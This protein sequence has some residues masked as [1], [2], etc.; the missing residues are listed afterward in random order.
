M[1]TTM[2][3]KIIEIKSND[4]PIS[5]MDTTMKKKIIEIKSNDI[6]ISTM[7]PF[8]DDELWNKLMKMYDKSVH[9]CRIYDEN[10]ELVY[11]SDDFLKFVTIDSKHI[12]RGRYY[13]KKEKARQEEFE[14]VKNKTTT[15]ICKGCK[16]EKP[17]GEFFKS[18]FPAR[19]L[20]NCVA[21]REETSKKNKEKKIKKEKEQKISTLEHK[22]QGTKQVITTIKSIDELKRFDKV[23][24]R[25]GNKYKNID[26]LNVKEE[27]CGGEV[28]RVN[29]KTVT[30]QIYE[31]E[32]Q[33]DYDYN[34]N[35]NDYNYR[36]EYPFCKRYSWKN[37]KF[38]NKTQT[39]GGLYTTKFELKEIDINSIL[40]RYNIT[41]VNDYDF[42]FHSLF[43]NGIYEEQCYIKY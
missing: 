5:T 43:T 7:N 3:E 9:L 8:D 15:H 30:L 26:D 39:K 28:T 33:K 29:K 36:N 22:V 18:K 35:D 41:K 21:C 11:A 34:D 12:I 31:L 2:K 4:I 42:H 23:I 20:I 32:E 1:D 27:Y 24:I 13:E 40:F 25:R 19:L 17:T 16:L 14:R 10:N 38:I 37:K 6:P